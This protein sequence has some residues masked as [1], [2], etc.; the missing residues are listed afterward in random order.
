MAEIQ[1]LVVIGGGAGGFAAAM[2]GVQLGS[3][4]QR[5]RGIAESW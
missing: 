3:L 2:R 4:M 5:G 1:D